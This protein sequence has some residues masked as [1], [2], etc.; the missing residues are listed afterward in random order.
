MALNK[1]LMV[2]GHASNSIDPKTGTPW[3]VICGCNIPDHQIQTPTEGLEGRKASCSYCGH[4]TESKW[5]LAFF[6]YR[7][8]LEFD[9]YYCGC[10]GWD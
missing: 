10:R 6:N 5:T 9:G 2:C 4:K 8:K 7:P 3:C 1:W